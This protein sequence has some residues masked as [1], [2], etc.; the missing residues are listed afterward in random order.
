[1]PTVGFDIPLLPR[2]DDVERLLVS[3]FGREVT[4]KRLPQLTAVEEPWLLADYRDGEGKLR[5]IAVCDK[6]LALGIGGALSLI[7]PAVVKESAGES[8]LPENLFLNAYEVLNVMTGLFNDHRHGA[9]HVRLGEVVETP[10]LEGEVKL[11]FEQ[12]DN[13]VDAGLE[14]AGGYG[15]GKLS[16]RVV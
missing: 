12:K 11:L 16:L 6:G 9:L 4:A 14:I 5:A 3:L 8:S 13:R 15:G 10:N 7:P 1:M 2:L